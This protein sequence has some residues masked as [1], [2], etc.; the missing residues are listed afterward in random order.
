[1]K[2]TTST[3]A[4]TRF[5]LPVSR[6]AGDGPASEAEIAVRRDLASAYRLCALFGWD[7]LIYTHISARVPGAGH[8]FLVNP[9]GLGFDEITAGNLVKID[10]D[11]NVV[12][13]SPYRPNAAGFVIHGAVHSARADASCVMHLHTEAGMALSILEEGLLPLSQ[14]AMRFSGRL[15]YHDYE[16]IALTMDEQRR[17]IADLGD[18][19]AL[20]LRNHGT[21]TVGRSVGHAF[22]E[23]FYLEKAARAQLLAQATGRPL[24]VPDPEVVELTTR[25]WVDDL[26]VSED[27]EWPSLLR[28]LERV[29]PSCRD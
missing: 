7:D 24:R 23:M 26:G 20:I 11:G 10:L 15:G 18:N 1:M 29:D 4:Y 16:G 9:L 25:Q 19:A 22:T 12:G 2:S 21:L 5:D 8:H 13:D 14:H 27:R 28:K 17:F 6:V 3:S